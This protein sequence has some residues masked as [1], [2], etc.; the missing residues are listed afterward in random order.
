MEIIEDIGYDITLGAGMGVFRA[1]PINNDLEQAY[2]RLK[3]LP[4]RVG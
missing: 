2:V 4:R 1:I 3:Y